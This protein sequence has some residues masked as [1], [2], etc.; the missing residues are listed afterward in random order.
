MG[1][2]PLRFHSQNLYNSGVI[3]TSEKVVWLM[4]QQKD[5]NTHFWGAVWDYLFNPA[6]QGRSSSYFLFLPSGFIYHL[7]YIFTESC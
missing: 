2:R 7:R 5:N 6:Q 3:G 4:T 1:T